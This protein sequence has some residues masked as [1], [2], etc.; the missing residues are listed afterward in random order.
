MRW[1]DSGG[2]GFTGPGVTPWLPLGEHP[3]RALLALSPGGPIPDPPWGNDPPNPPADRTVAGQ[4]DDPGSVLS[5]CRR[6]LALRRAELGRGLADFENL[7]VARGV[8]AYR[9]GSL[10]V[11]ANFTDQAGGHADGGGRGATDHLCR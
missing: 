7:A 3:D 4:R 1:D 10:V 11:A 2:G 6:L 8:W 5:L 9:T